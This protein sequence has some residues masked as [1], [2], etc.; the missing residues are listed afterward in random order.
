MF[1]SICRRCFHQ[2][3]DRLKTYFLAMAS[4]DLKTPLAAVQSYLQ[5]MLGGFVGELDDEHR[6]MLER[7]STRISELFDLINRFLD[8]AQI[9]K[10]GRKRPQRK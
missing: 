2:F 8:L 4:H 9:E 7:S 6:H 10:P 3:V 5:V 1:I